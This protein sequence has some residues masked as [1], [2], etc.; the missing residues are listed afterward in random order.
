MKNI[1]K[2]KKVEYKRVKFNAD[3]LKDVP[4]EDNIFKEIENIQIRAVETEEKFIF[5]TIYPFCLEVIKREFNK[6][7]LEDALKEYM[8]N[9]PE[10]FAE[11]EQ[12]E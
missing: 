2:P 10:R 3:D 9:H 8:Q 12:D 5:K 11:G 6:N 1:F 4:Y 7:L